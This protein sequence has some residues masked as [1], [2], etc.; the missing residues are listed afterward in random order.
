MTWSI[1]KLAAAGVLAAMP[2][3]AASLPAVAIADS[4]TAP[5]VLPVP[6]PA[7]PQIDP[8]PPAPQHGEYY[9]TNDYDDWYNT[10][11]DGGGG[12]GGGG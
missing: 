4:S 1:A 9:S 2:I 3:A 12:G 7:D 8:A 5:V 10:G 6:L 11:A